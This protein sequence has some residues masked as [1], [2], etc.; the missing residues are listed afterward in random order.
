MKTFFKKATAI[1][2]TAVMTVGTLG[3]NVSAAPEIMNWYAI[4]TT[5]SG[6]PGSV[7][8]TA[9]VS[10][11]ATKEVYTGTVNNM[12][13][14]TFGTVTI[15]SSTHTM[16]GG[17]RSYTNKGVKTWKLNESEI[18]SNDVRYTVAAYTD[19]AESTLR[20]DGNITR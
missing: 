8:H 17:S 14:L 13:A 11:L 3:I 1:V 15:S 16:I 4:Y 9:T 18:N 12:T 7:N 20:A 6:L 10:M 5:V 19:V 2:M